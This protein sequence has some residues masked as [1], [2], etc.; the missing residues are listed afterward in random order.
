M[1][2]KKREKILLVNPAIQ[3]RALSFMREFPIKCLARARTV[4]NEATNGATTEFVTA[5]LRTAATHV[6]TETETVRFKTA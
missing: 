4:V 1:G 5:C 6:R 3:W 2:K